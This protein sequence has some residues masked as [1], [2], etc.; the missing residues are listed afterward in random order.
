MFF[1]VGVIAQQFHVLVLDDHPYIGHTRVAEFYR[2]AVKGFMVPAV[3]SEV[4]VY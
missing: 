4:F 3:F 2:V 1:G